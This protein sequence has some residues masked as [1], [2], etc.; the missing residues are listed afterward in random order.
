MQQYEL[1]DEDKANLQ[2]YQAAVH[3]I[4]TGTAWRIGQ[5]EL[6]NK[7]IDKRASGPKHLRTGI[8]SAMINDNALVELLV[9][10]GVIT[11]SE[12]FAQLAVTAEEAVTA[13]EAEATAH[14]GGRTKFTFR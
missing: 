14:H 3:G 9:S 7:P 12:Y 5:D 1:T 8:D 11:R 4:Q 6:E 2:R 13:Y 10:K